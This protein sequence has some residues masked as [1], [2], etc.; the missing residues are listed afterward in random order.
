MTIQ[1]VLLQRKGEKKAFK[2]HLCY[3]CTLIVLSPEPV[4]VWHCGW[5]C[6]SGKHSVIL[7]S[8]VYY[9]VCYWSLPVNDNMWT[10]MPLS[11][12]SHLILLSVESTSYY[13]TTSGSWMPIYGC[14]AKKLYLKI[15]IKARSDALQCF[16]SQNTWGSS[17][18]RSFI[19]GY[20]FPITQLIVIMY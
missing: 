16:T 6:K 20:L 18:S 14:I 13:S 17:L 7:I 10:S 9:T 3:Y 12:V 1:A 19:S 2:A 8:L 4:F 15:M 11:I 5:L